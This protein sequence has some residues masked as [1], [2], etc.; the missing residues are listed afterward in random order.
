M[1]RNTDEHQVATI[2]TSYEYLDWSQLWLQKG[3][4]SQSPLIQHISFQWHDAFLSHYRLGVVC[5][6]NK[7]SALK[8]NKISNYLRFCCCLDLSF[9]PGMVTANSLLFLFFFF[10]SDSSR[11]IL[12]SQLLFM[13]LVSGFVR[14]T[15]PLPPPPNTVLGPPIW[16]VAPCLFS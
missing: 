3:I 16:A 10:F 8:S 4:S 15:H 5:M 9:L 12:F 6:I 11:H 2:L 1:D 13:L 14:S 7:P